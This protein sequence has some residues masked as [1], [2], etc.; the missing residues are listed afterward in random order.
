MRGRELEVASER[1]LHAAAASRCS[2]YDW[3]FVA[4]ARELGVPLYT[5][6]R[7]ILRS[8]P[9]VARPLTAA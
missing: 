5:N 1:V 2:A 8:F 9:G 7:A 4:L 3:E 6:D